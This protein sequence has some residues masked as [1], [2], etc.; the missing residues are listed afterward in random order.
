[1]ENLTE[2]LEFNNSIIAENAE[3]VIEL[4][5]EY[6]YNIYVNDKLEYNESFPQKAIRIFKELILENNLTINLC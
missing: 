6:S 3:I 4:R 5:K 2:H 1:M